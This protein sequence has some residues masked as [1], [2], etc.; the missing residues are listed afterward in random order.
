MQIVK[1]FGV[2]RLKSSNKPL[3]I[4]WKNV[5]LYIHIYRGK[6]RC[7]HNQHFPKRELKGR[8]TAMGSFKNS[9]FIL[10][11]HLL[12]G[13][14]SD[15]LIQLNNNGY[16]GIVIAIDPNV[17]EDETLIQHIEVSLKW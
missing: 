10:V 16:E 6:E 11:L 17:P 4:N 13:A 2:K 1:Q 7:L 14:L 5:C 3:L 9:V 12:E 8:C 15:S